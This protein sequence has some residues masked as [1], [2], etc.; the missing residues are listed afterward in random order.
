MKH[1]LIFVLL[2]VAGLMACEKEETTEPGSGATVEIDMSYFHANSW[3]DIY[4]ND[5]YKLRVSG[6]EKKFVDLPKN[7]KSKCTFKWM[8][9]NIEEHYFIVHERD[10]VIPY[11]KR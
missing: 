5:I 10:T 6:A 4:I 7:K 9:G 11:L 8:N 3:I 1:F 2:L